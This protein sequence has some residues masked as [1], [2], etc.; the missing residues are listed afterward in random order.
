[1]N[2]LHIALKTRYGDDFSFPLVRVLDVAHRRE[3][4]TFDEIRFI[5]SESFEDIILFAWSHKFLIPMAFSRCGEWDD[6]ILMIEP[7]EVYEMPNISR[8]LLKM[9]AE[10]GKWDIAG[11]VACLY[12]DMGEL[13]WEK[14]PDL[15]EGIV[16]NSAN[17]IVS[18]ASI[19]AACVKAG[20]KNR[21]GAMIAI[22]K[23][24]GV[25]SPKLAAIGPVAKSGAPIYEVNPCV[26]SNPETGV[27]PVC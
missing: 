2:K 24:G 18:A 7:G 8:Y 19:N 1:M 22:L 25:I 6:R 4:I 16:T 5:E 21:T 9:A 27:L 26:Y 12:K 17:F 11:A 10:T 23:G 20:I 13:F 15:V 14:M 3:T